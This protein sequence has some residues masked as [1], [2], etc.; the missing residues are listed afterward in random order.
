MDRD[1]IV[2]RL[3][4][5]HIEVGEP[6]ECW[7]WLASLNGVGYPQVNID[8]KVYRVHRLL[9]EIVYGPIPFE[10][11]HVCKNRWCVNPHHLLPTKNKREH[12]R[13][14]AADKATWDLI[15]RIKNKNV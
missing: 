13:Y 10:V 6:N 7:Y 14:H 11:H 8:G 12:L 2:N 1:K 4:M 3:W 9:A 15:E 5:D